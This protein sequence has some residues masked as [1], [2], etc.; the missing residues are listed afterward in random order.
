[1][2]RQEDGIVIQCSS[3]KNLTNAGSKE[4]STTKW[5][6]QSPILARARALKWFFPPMFIPWQLIVL[7]NLLDGHGVFLGIGHSGDNIVIAIG[8][9]VVVSGPGACSFDTIAKLVASH[10]S[11]MSEF[12]LF[13]G[14]HFLVPFDMALFTTNVLCLVKYLL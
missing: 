7:I 13:G 12:E 11:V 14:V 5:T 4:S 9:A 1:M 3:M 6:Y 8:V 10:A 2:I